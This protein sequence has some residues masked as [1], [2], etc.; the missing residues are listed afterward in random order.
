MMPVAV[1]PTLLEDAMDAAVLARRTTVCLGAALLVTVWG[2]RAFAAVDETLVGTWTTSIQGFP[3]VAT[4]HA[5]GRC[6]VADE[7]GRCSTKGGA[8][9]FVGEEETV[10]FRWK[11]DQGALHLSGGD[12]DAPLRFQRV[13]GAAPSP[14]PK[15]AASTAPQAVTPTQPTAAE[16]GARAAVKM[17]AWGVSLS[18]PGGWKSAE[19]N[20]LLLAGSDTEA[21]LLVVRFFP[22]TTR[23]E[24]VAG[25]QAGVHEDGVNAAPTSEISGFE[26]KGGKG[27]AGVLEGNAADGTPLRIRTVAVMSSHG[28]AVVVSGITTPQMYATLAARTDMV[29]RSVVFT[30]PPK[31][32]P[33][34]GH[35]QFIYVSPSGGYSREAKLTLCQSGSFTRSGELAGSGPA[36]SAVT[37]HGNGGSWVAVGS[38]ASGTLT[39]TW[40]NGSVTSL[41]YQVSNNPKDRSSYG[42]AVRFGN[43]L[44]QKTGAG[45]C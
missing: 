34:A 20:G 8:L 16:R 2:G 31:S 18:F 27:L 14:A 41:P 25:Y 30:A 21:G 39:L 15:P 43:D 11:V 32:A 22:K 35:Y 19:K 45:G 1:G 24:L 44:Y 42:P 36:G 38:G 4:F 9:V 13:G 5:D 6:T 40:P 26:A 23:Q 17:D 28:G 12:L 33:L 29:A 10:T 7:P 3:F 37:A